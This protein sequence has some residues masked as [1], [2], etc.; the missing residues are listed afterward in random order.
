MK[1]SPDIDSIVLNAGV[2]NTY[3]L[4]D[5]KSFD[6]AA[7]LEEVKINFFSFVSL[8]HALLPYLQKNPNSTSFIL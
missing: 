6:L 2:Q 7:F 8:T 3:D 1:E 4:T 5:P